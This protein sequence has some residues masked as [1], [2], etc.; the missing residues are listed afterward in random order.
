MI[1]LEYMFFILFG[2]SIIFLV[3]GSLLLNLDW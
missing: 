1:Y 2:I 3:V